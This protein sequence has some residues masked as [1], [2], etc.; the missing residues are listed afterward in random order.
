MLEVG[1][2]LG[3]MGEPSGVSASVRHHQPSRPELFSPV[4][5]FQSS[6]VLC[7]FYRLSREQ[8]RTTHL[9]GS[10]TETETHGLS[11]ANGFATW[12]ASGV[13]TVRTVRTV[14]LDEVLLF[15]LGRVHHRH[16]T[17]QLH[18]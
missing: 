14:L 16:S 15:P 6:E 4:V 11:E 5:L 12:G 7:H 2:L 17:N 1:H 10:Q 18:A 9:Y 8:K 3:R 13:R